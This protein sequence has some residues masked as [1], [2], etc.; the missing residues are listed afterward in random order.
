MKPL[1]LDILLIKRGNVR[2]ISDRI[3]MLELELLSL[4]TQKDRDNASFNEQLG[5]FIILISR[6]SA[7]KNWRLKDAT[8]AALWSRAGCV[9]WDHE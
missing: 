5:R 7:G 6:K 9:N 4:Q 3:E 2:E 8:L 1:I